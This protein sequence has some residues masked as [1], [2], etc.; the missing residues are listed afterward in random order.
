MWNLQVILLDL[1]KQRNILQMESLGLC[2]VTPVLHKRYHHKEHFLSH[3]RKFD[4]VLVSTRLDQN[5]FGQGGCIVR[6]QL[7][8]T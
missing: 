7:G 6:K 8:K 2:I 3:I 1:D 4:M 5:N